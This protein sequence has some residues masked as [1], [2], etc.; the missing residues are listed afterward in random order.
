M[1]TTK[2]CPYCGEEIKMKAIKCRHCKTMLVNNPNVTLS[3]EDKIHA[4]SEV[5]FIPRE[6][7]LWE[8]AGWLWIIPKSLTLELF[9]VKNGIVTIKTKNGNVIEAPLEKTSTHYVYD[10]RNESFTEYTVKTEDGKKIRF[11]DYSHLEEEDWAKI[12]KIL[13]AQEGGF[14]KK[15]G[16]VS[17]ILSW[18]N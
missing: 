3:E 13:H 15:L 16:V 6:F 11:R 18:I 4:G 8:K 2:K 7:T 9:R 17:K 10:S 12:A 1:V 14:S 5:E